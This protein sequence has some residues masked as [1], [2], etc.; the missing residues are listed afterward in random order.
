MPLHPSV[1]AK[2]SRPLALALLA[3]ALLLPSAPI[4]ADHDNT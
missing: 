3:G 2:A 4:L 1:L